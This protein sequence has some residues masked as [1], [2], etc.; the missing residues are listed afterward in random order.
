M[1]ND[2]MMADDSPVLLSQPTDTTDKELVV[3]SN[4]KYGVLGVFVRNFE[5]HMLVK[6]YFSC[7]VKIDK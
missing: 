4:L 3:L 6:L 7:P 2:I 5:I 1:V